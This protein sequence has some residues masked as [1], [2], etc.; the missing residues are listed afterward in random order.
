MSSERKLC[1]I[2][3]FPDAETAAN[4]FDFEVVERYGNAYKNWRGKV[5]H[6]LHTWDDGGRALIRCRKCGA[7]FLRQDSEYR[8]TYGGDSYYTDLFSVKNRNEAIAYNKKYDGYAIERE[9]KGAKIWNS[10]AGWRWNM[11][12]DSQ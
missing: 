11:T 8:G 1:C 4:N 12:Q 10:N 7:L 2:F 3:S 9:Y 6:H 5:I